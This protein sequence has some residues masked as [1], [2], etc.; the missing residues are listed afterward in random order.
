MKATRKNVYTVWVAPGTS[1]LISDHGYGYFFYDVDESEKERI[2]SF[3]SKEEAENCLHRIMVH[4]YL[5][6]DGRRIKSRAFATIREASNKYNLN[7]HQKGAKYVVFSPS[8]VFIGGV[9]AER[10]K[11]A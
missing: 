2:E 9:S 3:D 7:V 11:I 5:M 4:D 6:R 8:V 10:Q 1:E